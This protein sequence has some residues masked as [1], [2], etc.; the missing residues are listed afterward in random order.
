MEV[1]ERARACSDGGYSDEVLAS[2]VGASSDCAG[3]EVSS[4]QAKL[5]TAATDQV[6]GRERDTRPDRVTG[7]VCVACAWMGRY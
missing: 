3:K 2:L 7:A 5:A 6:A 1:L 4:A